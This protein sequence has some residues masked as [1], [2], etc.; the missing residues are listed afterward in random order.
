M[1][2]FLIIYGL[3]GAVTGAWFK[4]QSASIAHSLAAGIAWPLCVASFVYY[5]YQ[6]RRGNA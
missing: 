3:I 1:L 4:Y 5:T 2:E 6:K